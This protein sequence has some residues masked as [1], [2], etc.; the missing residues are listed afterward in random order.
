MKI[1]KKGLIFNTEGKI[2]DDFPFYA[3][4]PFADKYDDYIRIYY[5]SRTRD[6]KSFPFYIDVDYCD[7]KKIIHINKNPLLAL[8]APGTFDDNGIT[9]SS[10]VSVG[11]EKYLYYIGWNKRV[12]VPYALNIGLAISKNNGE[13]VK[14][15]EGPLLDR[16]IVDPI[17]ST[18]PCVLFDENNFKMWYV[19]CLRWVEVFGKMEPIYVIKYAESDNGIEWKRFDHICL[20]S[21]FDGEALGRPWVIKENN[22]F[23]MWYSSRGSKN[24]RDKSGEHYMIK[25]AE[26][27]DGVNWERKDS[28]FLMPLSSSGW[29]SEMQEYCSVITV[30]GIKYLL[31]N[32]NLFGKTGFGYAV[33]GE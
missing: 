32:G 33:L 17:F 24:Y 18:A 31:Y 30:N 28:E 15:S 10:I 23:K 11:N 2:G 9:A 16:H 25:Y 5:S 27:V 3:Q 20:N 1:E 19:S 7:M 21:S 22:L 4:I 6:V 8:G 13:F 29:D 14:L 12:S 26:S